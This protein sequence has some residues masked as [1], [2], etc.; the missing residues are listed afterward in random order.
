MF[1][2]LWNNEI[3]KKT[4]H[5]QFLNF[6]KAPKIAVWNF[7]FNVTLKSN[8]K[9]LI[10][11]LVMSQSITFMLLCKNKIKKRIDCLRIQFISESHPKN[12]FPQQLIVTTF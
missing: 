11:Q 4:I 7:H 5:S 1:I 6:V 8:W 2:C 9:T 3:R 12:R 10:T